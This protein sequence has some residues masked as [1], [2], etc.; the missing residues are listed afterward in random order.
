M[1]AKRLR[2]LP[3]IALLFIWALQSGCV[4]NKAP[5]LSGQEYDGVARFTL[6][7]LKGQKVSLR[8]FRGKVVLLAFWGACCQKS[9]ES[10][11][12]LQEIWDRYRDRGFELVSINKDPPDKQSE[13]RQAVRR[14]RYRFPVL[15]DQESEVSNRFNPTMAFPF[16]VLLDRQGRI[17]RVFEGYRV[18]DEVFIEEQIN[19]ILSR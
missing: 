17:V 2:W 9:R 12:G 8:D 10:L 11:Q 3:L 19:K 14:Y 1:T 18:G 4:M 15:L 5:G 13:V 16:H 7:D 6:S